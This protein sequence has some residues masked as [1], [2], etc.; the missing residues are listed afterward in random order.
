MQKLLTD[1][2]AEF[3]ITELPDILDVKS[4]SMFFMGWYSTRSEIFTKKVDPLDTDV[5]TEE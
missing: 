5:E 3:D 2:F 4:Q 1:A